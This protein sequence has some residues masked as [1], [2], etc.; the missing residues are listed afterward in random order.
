M[1]AERDPMHDRGLE[2]P[3]VVDDPASIQIIESD[4][5]EDAVRQSQGRPLPSALPVRLANRCVP[6]R[7]IIWSASRSTSPI[8]TRW[9]RRSS[10]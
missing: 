10:G 6:A 3:G 1:P 7:P 9:K 2:G 8:R 4:N 5:V